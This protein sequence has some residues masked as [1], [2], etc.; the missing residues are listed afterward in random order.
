MTRHLCYELKH[1]KKGSMSILDYVMHVHKLIDSL[2]AI[3]EFIL[4]QDKIDTILDGLP[5]EYI[6]VIMVIL[7]QRDSLSLMEIEPLL[8]VQQ[9]LL[10]KFRSDLL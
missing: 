3:G 1:M 5:V 4:E 8:F 10:D 6:P 2:L 9:R 7:V